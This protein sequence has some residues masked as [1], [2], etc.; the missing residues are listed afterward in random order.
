LRDTLTLAE[1][2]TYKKNHN[3]QFPEEFRPFTI[4]D[5]VSINKPVISTPNINP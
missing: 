3:G 4:D 1:I 5:P 2:E